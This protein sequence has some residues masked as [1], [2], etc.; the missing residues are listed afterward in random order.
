MVNF[1]GKVREL[2]VERK[3]HLSLGGKTKSKMGN[4]RLK[5]KKCKV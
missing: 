2:G 1:L 5:G 3:V 4:L